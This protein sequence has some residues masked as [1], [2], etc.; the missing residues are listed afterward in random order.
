MMQRMKRTVGMFR[1]S[2]TAMIVGLVCGAGLGIASVA[3][4]ANA[5][6][7]AYGY[8]A[9]I[10][11]YQ[12]GT[13]SIMYTD[14]PGS[15]SDWAATTVFPTVNDSP[16]G[17]GEVPA[18]YM[19]ADARKFING[20][21]CEQTGYYYNS[22]KASNQKVFAQTTPCGAGTYYSYGLIAVWNGSGYDYYYSEKSPSANG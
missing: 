11:G 10:D 20:S 4:A 2:T 12:Y 21:V 18:G 19:G 5:T 1:A 7:S 9:T 8:T 16:A 13:R 22:V 17:S 15:P 3:L 6:Y 14:E